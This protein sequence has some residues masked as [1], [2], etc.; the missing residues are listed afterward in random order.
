[1]SST[2]Q[3]LKEYIDLHVPQIEAT[4]QIRKSSDPIYINQDRFRN[5]AGLFIDNEFFT[6]FDFRMLVGNSRDIDEPNTI[7]LTKALAEK[8]FGDLDCLSK[9]LIIKE[10]I[11]TVTGIIDNPPGNSSI[12]FE[13]LVPISNFFKTL[14]PLYSYLSVETYIKSIKEFDSYEHISGLLDEFFE[15][16][17]IK[18]KEMFSV[19]LGKL[20]EIHQYFSKTS[21]NFILF[22][23][24]SLLVLIVS[25]VNFVNTFAAGN[26]LRIHETGIRKVV[27]ASRAVLIR[28]MLVQSVLLTLLAAILGSILS[29]IF[30]D[31]FRKL[32]GASVNQYG[33]GLWWIQMLMIVI[34]VL[35]GLLAGIFPSL[36]Y[37]SSDII[38]MIRGNVGL[39]GGSFTLRKVLITGQYMISAGLL[40]CIFIFYSQLSYLAKKDPGYTSENRILIGVSPALEFKYNTYIEELRKIPGIV[41]VSGNGSS[42]G[43]TVGMSMMKEEG[44]EGFPVMGYF[45]E[46]DFFEAYGIDVVSGK[47]FSQTSGA[48]TGKVIID[49]ATAEIFGFDDPVGKKIFTSSL[50]EV[51]ILGVVRNTDLIARKGERNPFLYTQF[52]N[53]CA[54]L[55]IHYQGDAENIA[56]EVA[57]RL[58]KFDSEFEYNY[59]TVDEA[60]ATLY[61]EEANQVKIVLFVGIIAVI[62]T[63]VGAY[64][65]ATY[66]AERRARQVSIRKVMGATVAEVLQ[67]S[68]REMILMILIA[69]ALATPIAYMVGIRWLQ[70]FTMK[71][72]IGIL[73][74]LLSLIV[75]ASLIFITVYFKERKAAMVNPVENLRND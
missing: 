10:N 22:I 34:A 69:F 56:R 18:S 41:S 37:S 30:I 1:M 54:E 33:P 75:L 67:L 60:R 4:C 12:K 14:P 57:A 52:Y 42:F 2:H 25:V 45:V 48:D 31:T 62:L 23:T 44:E 46:D 21:K 53:I 38:S 64:S 74:F 5:H 36:R 17:D 40:I 70:N 27:G 55:I 51:E 24:I 29:G 7:I 50:R 35:T 9:T 8:L 71:I 43:Q 58:Q 39:R 6:I 3:Q 65:M 20:S 13:Y 61:E 72:S 19:K 47:T 49:E 73:P 15:V 16:Y 66:M 28:S 11:Y 63:L 26:E 32:A 68:I 59:R